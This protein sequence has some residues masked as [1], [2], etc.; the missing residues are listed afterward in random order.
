MKPLQW[1]ENWFVNR[2]ETRFENWLEKK[3]KMYATEGDEVEEVSQR[4]ANQI[5]EETEEGYKYIIH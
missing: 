2:L 5:E 3:I 4:L 1:L